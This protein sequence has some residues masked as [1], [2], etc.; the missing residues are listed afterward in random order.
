[1]RPTLSDASEKAAGHNIS[2]AIIKEM[3]LIIIL[4]L[5]RFEKYTIQY[6]LY[7]EIRLKERFLRLNPFALEIL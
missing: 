7:K 5:I 3:Y 2:K 1:M 6:I 4:L